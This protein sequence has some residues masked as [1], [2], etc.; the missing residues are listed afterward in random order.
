[1]YDSKP[2]ESVT[3]AVESPAED[4]PHQRHGSLNRVPNGREDVFADKSIDRISK[5][6]LMKFLKFVADF[7]N[8]PE[9]WQTSESTPF[10]EFVHAQFGLSPAL[11]APLLAISMS[12][13]MPKETTTAYALPSIARHLR[14]IGVF[15]PGFG[16]VVP[17]WGGAAEIA[18]VACRAGAVGGGVYVLGRGIEEITSRS[19]KTLDDES[20]ELLHVKLQDGETV[21]TRWVAGSP[22]NVRLPDRLQKSLPSNESLPNRSILKSISIVSS[23]LTS[24]FPTTAEGAPPPA[25]A[26]M[27][28]PSG[29]LTASHTGATAVEHPPV[30]VILHSSDTGECPVGQG[31]HSSVWSFP[32]CLSHAYMMIEF[33]NTYLHCLHLH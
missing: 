33:V 24:L 29:S 30:H 7:E 21:K 25:G 4:R 10:S 26:V 27:I 20:K 19:D 22:N 12:P 1:M 18:Q 31:T 14:S 17:K 11:C 15:G 3:S 13:E 6:S 8:D 23:P 5:R 16:A 32:R 9:A 28:F 2:I